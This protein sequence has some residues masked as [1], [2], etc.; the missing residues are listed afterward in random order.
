MGEEPSGRGCDEIALDANGQPHNPMINSGAILS[1]SMLLYLVQPELSTSEKFEFVQNYFQRLAGGMPVGFQNTTF[2]SE[3]E[4]SD[5]DRAL[6]FFMRENGCFPKEPNT[7]QGFVDIKT[8]LDFYFQL[9]SLEMTTESMSV[10]AATLANG[11]ICPV[12]SERVLDTESVKNVLSLM[13]SC[14]MNNNGGQFAF[15]VGLP[16]KSSV[17]GIILVIVPNV[18]G[19]ATWSPALNAKGNSVRGIMFFQ[20]LVKVYRFHMFDNLGISQCDNKKN[21]TV[22]NYESRSQNLVRILIAAS[23]GDRMALERAHLADLDMN[24]ADYDGR[25]ALHLAACEGHLACVRFLLE[26]CEVE[27]E[28]R[29]RWGHTPLWE[30]QMFS[31]REVVSLLRRHLSRVRMAGCQEIEEEEEA[32]IIKS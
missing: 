5:R 3:R 17:S 10:M 12:T 14:G 19:F 16:A 31:R 29:D 7:T 26:V 32:T 9:C 21:P 30:A 13:F 22:Q 1:A 4:A 20:E 6:A 18:M 25:T 8:I 23:N 15:K 24:A 27:A 2:L 11:G 28:P